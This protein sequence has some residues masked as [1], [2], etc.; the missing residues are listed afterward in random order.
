MRSQ[1]GAASRFS[2]NLT[3]QSLT[4]ARELN[5]RMSEGIGRVSPSR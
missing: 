3:K 4:I 1:E 2:I 5:D